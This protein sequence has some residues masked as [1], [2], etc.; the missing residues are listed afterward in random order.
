MAAAAKGFFKEKSKGYQAIMAAEKVFRAFEFAMSVRAMVQDVAETISSVA[1]SGARATAAG[2]EGVANQSKLPFPFNIAAMAAT[3]AAL[4]A[5]GIAIL[6]AEEAAPPRR[7]VQTAGRAPSSAIPRAKRKPS[8]GRS[9]P[10][11]RWTR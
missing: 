2:A 11:G 3:A 5:A 9:M 1:N 6:E 10:S 7:P 4:V 8:S